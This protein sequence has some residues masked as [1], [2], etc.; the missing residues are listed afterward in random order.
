MFVLNFWKKYFP[1]ELFFFVLYVSFKAESN[2]MGNVFRKF[3]N[4]KY[5]LP[6]SDFAMDFL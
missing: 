4:K 3:K 6:T 5:Q 1:Q 2:L